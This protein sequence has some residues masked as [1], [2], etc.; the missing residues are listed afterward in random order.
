MKRKKKLKRQV[1]FY[2]MMA[3]GLF[4]IGLLCYLPLPGL[5][6]AFKD[7]NPIQGILGSEFMD[8]WYKNF[9]FFFKSESAKT[10]TF[11][12]LFYNFLE[13]VLI[14]A[15]AVAL[16]ILLNEVKNKY[17]S[18]FYKG[19]ILIPTFLSWVVIQYILFSFLSVDRG[20]VNNVMGQEIYWYSEPGYWR[21][22]MPL[23]YVWKNIGYYSVLYVAAIAGINTDYYEAA[24]LDG[25]TKWQQ[26]RHITL[27]L[28]RPTVIVLSLLWV[29]KLFNGGLGDWNGFYTLPN[30]SGALY[31]ATDVIDTYVF[32]SLR[33]IGDYGMSAAVG[34]YQSIVGFV[35]V[36]ISNTVIKK[37]DPD[38]ALF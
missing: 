38:S 4:L 10:V 11:N 6:V 30:D 35:L 27:P 2:L 19:A 21:F 17:L 20:I 25:A 13:A 16:A 9:E 3:P 22:I 33:T 37:V 26:I 5:L 1:P 34:L 23:A 12:T 18:G 32:R 15:G 36:L 8:P 14:T 31:A 29:G 24:Q 7:Y 28:I